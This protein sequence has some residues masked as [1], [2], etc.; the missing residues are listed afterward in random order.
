MSERKIKLVGKV[1]SMSLV[2]REYADMNYNV[3]AKLAREL[4]PGMIWVTSGATEIGRL[5]YVRRTGKEIDG[6][7]DDAKMDYAAQG[8]SLLMSKY[9]EYV[10]SEYSLRQ[11]LVEHQHFNDAV[12]RESLLRMLLRCPD[13]NAIPVINYNDAVS[14]EENR[15]LEIAKLSERQQNVVQC[16]DNDE[17]AGRI[18]SLVDP[19]VLLILTTT[20]GIYADPTDPDTL[21]TDITG[22]DA[23]ELLYNIEQCKLRCHG[24]SRRG[25]GGAFAKLEYIKEP[26]AGGT[27]VI[28]GNAKYGIDAFLHSD[29]PHTAIYLK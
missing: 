21:I 2:D 18:A 3:I 10:S 6:N 23:D 13:Q 4:R 8:Q 9:R 26:A 22:H 19:E 17:T 20:N 11:I 14:Y 27:R 15:K 12:K 29:V 1:G 5:D 28:I 7:I 24:T 16:V 25:S